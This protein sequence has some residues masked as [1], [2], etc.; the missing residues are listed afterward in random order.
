MGGTRGSGCR[1]N[2]VVI[3]VPGMCTSS[4]GVL[5]EMEECMRSITRFHVVG[6]L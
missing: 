5:G 3:S 4:G 6:E 1:R 2:S